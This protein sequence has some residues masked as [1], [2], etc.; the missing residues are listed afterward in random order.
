MEDF[1]SFYNRIGLELLYPETEDGV[2]RSNIAYNFGSLGGMKKREFI[3]VGLCSL[4]AGLEMYDFLIFAVFAS[5]IGQQFLNVES[6]SLAT[7]FAFLILAIGYLTRPLGGLFFGAIGDKLGRKKMFNLTMILMAVVTIG[8]ALLPTYHAIGLAAPLILIL[9]RLLQG[10]SAGGELPGAIVYIKE[11]VHT[12]TIF[13]MSVLFGVVMVSILVAQLAIYLVKSSPD[14]DFYWRAAFLFGGAVGI[15]SAYIRKYLHESPEFIK[16]QKQN[17]P[18]KMI[19]TSYKKNLIS[20]VCITAFCASL[21]TMFFLVMRD[22]F[23][24]VSVY[25]SSAIDKLILYGIVCL[26]IL[27]LLV[28]CFIKVK[29]LFRTM[30]IFM[31]FILGLSFLLCF[32]FAAQFHEYLMYTIFILFYFML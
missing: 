31:P 2:L 6:K 32:S 19:F 15:V 21:V 30:Y 27:V 7:F 25:S 3:I 9:L 14:P 29:N 28:G 17:S 8:V 11:S 4:G 13:P 16:M 26:S 24:Y 12:K 5:T 23:S 18:I 20:V 10:L 22:Y 1:A